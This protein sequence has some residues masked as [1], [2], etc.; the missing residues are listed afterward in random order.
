MAQR[1]F[2]RVLFTK[3]KK[4][5]IMNIQEMDVVRVLHAEKCANQRILAEKSG[6]SLGVVNRCV[7]SLTGD[8]Y[9]N[10]ELQLTVKGREMLAG[11]GIRNAIILAAGFGMR[12][13]PI[14]LSVPKPLLEVKR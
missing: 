1:D 9:L 3:K 8:G 6:H 2:L 13:V 5:E 12:M 14:N 7:R 10:E 4:E 11:K